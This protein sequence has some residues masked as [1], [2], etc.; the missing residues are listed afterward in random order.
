MSGGKGVLREEIQL[1]EGR[2]IQIIGQNHLLF[3]FLLSRQLARLFEAYG[4]F[5]TLRPDLVVPL[6]TACL[7]T[8][9]L[10]PL[11]E[12]GHQPPPVPLMAAWKKKFDS[13]L[14]LS[15]AV[16]ALAMVRRQGARGLGEGQGRHTVKKGAGPA[17]SGW[18][19]MDLWIRIYGLDLPYA[20]S[21]L[22]QTPPSLT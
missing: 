13:R 16:V 22:R 5:L 10:L 19:A 9:L 12:P 1:C 8:M 2:Q 3:G 11:E 18:L 15:A 14:S 17:V 21:C 4:R 7:S 6:V 20:T